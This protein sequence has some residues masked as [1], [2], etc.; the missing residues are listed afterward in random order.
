[1]NMTGPQLAKHL[2]KDPA[3]IRKWPHKGCPVIRHGAKGPGRGA[4]FDLAA[5]EAWLGR[6]NGPCVDDVMQRIAMALWECLEKDRADIRA[7]IS[8]EDAAAV[9]V[10]LWERCCKNFGVSFKFDAQPKPIRALIARIVE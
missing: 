10:I 8:P 1:M 3:T 9:F 5:V 7:G 2:K 6:S 4:L